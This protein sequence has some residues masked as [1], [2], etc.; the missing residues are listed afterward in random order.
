LEK[1]TAVITLKVSKSFVWNFVPMW[2]R[3]MFLTSSQDSVI[4]FWD[5][6]T[7]KFISRYKA[8]EQLSHVE[9]DEEHWPNL[10]VGGNNQGSVYFWDVRKGIEHKDAI[11]V[12][13]ISTSTPTSSS[14]SSTS[15]LSA[16]APPSGTTGW[17]AGDVPSIFEG[18]NVPTLSVSATT[19]PPPAVIPDFDET[20]LRQLHLYHINSDIRALTLDATRCAVATK[21][22][23]I[24]FFDMATFSP[25][26]AVKSPTVDYF[27]ET[28]T[29]KQTV[30]K[31]QISDI[32][33]RSVELSDDLLVLG[34]RTGQLQ[35]YDFG[36]KDNFFVTLS[37]SLQ[38]SIQQGL[39]Q[40]S[41]LFG[42]LT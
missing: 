38:Q 34:T 8:E 26:S 18:N 28:N 37:S 1:K 33:A 3:H 31:W 25:V 30:Y 42:S 35:I 5:E 39:Q 4:R 36:S 22:N 20:N 14:S 13:N 40:V 2:Y 16:S 15:Q 11:A 9:C 29:S 21:D 17:M 41:K 6:R 7:H 10:L 32:Q 12:H 24:S 23:K 19:V 27:Y